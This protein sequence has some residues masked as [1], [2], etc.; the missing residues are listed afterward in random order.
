M[1]NAE[2]ARWACRVE[3]DKWDQDAT[4]WARNRLAVPDLALSREQF[5]AL[6]IR[7]FEQ[8]VVDPGNQLADT[9]PATG[10]EF[11]MKRVFNIGT[12]P[13]LSDNTHTG[14]GVGSTAT[15]DAG[16]E[17]GLL[18]ASSCWNPMVATY[19]QVA[20]NTGVVTLQ[21]S[22]ATAASDFA[23]NEYG[24]AIPNASGSAA[25]SANTVAVVPTG[26]ALLNR[27]APAALG[28][29][30]GGTWTLTMTLTIS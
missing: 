23:W 5:A 17:T 27:K 26:Y 7:P 29:K 15:A 12:P 6:G 8:V 24:A 3:V 21:A 13:A 28:T 10:V 25:V 1:T 4:D 11:L 22:F 18:F 14:L 19:P 20:A 30:S 16:N 2:G 9:S